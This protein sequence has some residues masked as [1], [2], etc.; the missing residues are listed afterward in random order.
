MSSYL[1]AEAPRIL[2]PTLAVALGDRGALFV[3]QV[4]YWC[5]YHRRARTANHYQEG[6]W[7]TYNTVQGWREQF[8]FWSERT[9]RRIIHRLE[10]KGVLL[11]GNYNRARYDRTLWYAVDVGRVEALVAAVAPDV[12]QDHADVDGPR[13]TGKGP[14]VGGL[15]E[16]SQGP[17]ARGPADRPDGRGQDGRM[18]ADRLS[19]CKRPVDPGARGQSGQLQGAS[20]PEP[21]PKRSKAV[22]PEVDR[23]WSLALQELE[24]QM[25]RQ[26]FDTWVKPLALTGLDPGPTASVGLT[27]AVG[28]PDSGGRSGGWRAAIH[29][30]NDYSRAWCE[31]RLGVLFERALG[32][33]LGA[34]VEIAYE[35]GGEGG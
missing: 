22:P 16:P 15:P 32:G 11:V 23:V 24:L 13:E 28:E 4:Y 35:V 34:P 18:Q 29:C 6:H 27:E 17:E 33:I 21:I 8:P 31:E 3:Q 25:T 19:T 26:T 20:L 7:W 1:L 14:K 9:I 12:R 2:L 10:E 5:E 30:P